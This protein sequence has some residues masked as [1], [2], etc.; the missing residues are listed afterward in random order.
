MKYNNVYIDAFECT[1]PEVVVTTDQ[2]EQQL[3]PLYKRLHLPDGRLEL[4]TGIRQRRLWFPG[5]MPGECSVRTGKRLLRT[6]GIDPERIGMF[7]HGSVC[8][9]YQEPATAAGVHNELGLSQHAAVFDVSNACLG[10]LTGMFLIANAIELGQIEAGIVVGT[11]NS[12]PLLETTVKTLNADETLT[13]NSIKNA[14]ASLTIGSGSCA[15]VLTNERQTRTGNRLLGGAIQ[16]NT[17]QC[18]LCRSAKDVSAGGDGKGQLMSTDSETLLHEGV[19]VARIC[20][21]RFCRELDLASDSIDHYFCHQVG[22]AHERLLCE[23]LGLDANKNFTTLPWLGNT[24]SVAL[25][26]AAAIG[27]ASG[28][29]S[30]GETLAMLGIGSGINT[31]MF[32]IQW[33]KTFSTVS[34]EEKELIDHIVEINQSRSKNESAAV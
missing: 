16:A 25:P 19:A 17:K 21:E 14:F 2:L 26:T 18:H 13:R 29:V 31:A 32:A 7:I 28:F 15:V 10:I 8:R 27:T 4:M 22:K 6:S 23:Q 1:F 20:Y 3:A 33:N 11:E 24:G 34:L 12:R 5:E 30:Q 9:D